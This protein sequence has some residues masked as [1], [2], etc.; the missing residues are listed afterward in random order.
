MRVRFTPRA[1]VVIRPF[2]HADS[3]QCATAA[4]PHTPRQPL[5]NVLPLRF[6]CLLPAFLYLTASLRRLKFP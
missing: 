6:L 2:S 3:Q 5:N 4:L 1:L